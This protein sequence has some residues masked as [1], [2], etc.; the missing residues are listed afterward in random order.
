MN[1]ENICSKSPKTESKNFSTDRWHSF[2]NSHQPTK[3]PGKKPVE[4]TIKKYEITSH[5][6]HMKVL[7]FLNIPFSV[8]ALSQTSQATHYDRN[9][10]NVLPLDVANAV[11]IYKSLYFNLKV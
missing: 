9:M 1:S 3:L 2:P 5:S 10:K 6:W 4:H 8:A 7:W 11:Y